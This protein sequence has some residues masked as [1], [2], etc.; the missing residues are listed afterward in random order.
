MGNSDITITAPRDVRM[1]AV[2]SAGGDPSNLFIGHYAELNLTAAPTA[3][4][5][6]TIG[7][8]RDLITNAADGGNVIALSM[9]SNTLMGAGRNVTFNTADKSSSSFFSAE[10][11]MT[12]VVDQASGAAAGPGK[13]MISSR[14]QI[15][16]GGVV[17]GIS[18]I[19][20]LRI[21]TSKR[22]NNLIENK[23]TFWVDGDSYTFEAGPITGQTTPNGDWTY[24]SMGNSAE[25]EQWS[26]VWNGTLNG[27]GNFTVPFTV[28]YKDNAKIVPTFDPPTLQPNPWP[29]S[30]SNALATSTA[31]TG[32]GQLLNQEFLAPE[33]FQNDREKYYKRKN[34]Q[35]RVRAK[36]FA[37]SLR[38]LGFTLDEGEILNTVKKSNRFAIERGSFLSEPHQ[39][40]ANYEFVAR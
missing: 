40:R 20:E 6:L 7:A 12:I 11:L 37:E 4:D 33:E 17:S 38:Q 2:G 28:F 39:S 9:G 26:T 25:R 36:A 34:F 29:T 13:F 19:D 21:Y 30:E 24:R 15:G 32:L 1:T 3:T 23:T 10:K 22:G 5:N 31:F 14:S 18:S 16:L 8:G 27:G 35:F